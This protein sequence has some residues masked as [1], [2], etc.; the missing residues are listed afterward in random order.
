VVDF[1]SRFSL[2]ASRSAYQIGDYPF[3]LAH[4]FLSFATKLFKIP[5]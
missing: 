1:S 5:I 3:G 2:P 4:F